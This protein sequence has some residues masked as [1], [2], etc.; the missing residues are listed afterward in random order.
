M[1]DATFYFP[2]DFLW[3]TA[4]SAH[5]VEGGNDNND[6]WDWEQKGEGRVFSDHTSGA[7]CEWWAG[8][9]EEDVQRMADLN[10]NAHRL[11]IE[12]SRIEPREG[13]WDHSAFDRY[14]DILKAML[15]AGIQPMITLHHFTNPMWMVRKGGWLHPE[16]P[17]WFQQF[18]RRVV[19]DLSDLCRVWC[20]INEP[21]VYAA[22]GF[23]DGDWPPGQT[24]ISDY[25]RVVYHMLQAHAAAYETIHDLQ[26][27]AR[28]GLA[29]HMIA[30]YP[31]TGSPLDRMITNLLDRAFNGVTLD[32]LQAGKWRPPVG[33]KDEMPGV[34]NT[35]DWIGLNYYQR[36]DAA[37]NLKALRSL[38]I[39]YAARPGM[40][41]GPEGW[42]EIY[43]DGLF[44]LLKRLHRQFNLPITITE[45]GLPDEH[46]T[47]RPGF[48]LE[49]LYRVW[50]A[51]NFNWPIM[52]YY[53]WSLVD[54]FEWAEGY[55]PRFRFGL[56]GVDFETQ[57]RTLR[58]SG[59]LYAEIA[60]TR[61]FSSHMARRYAPEVVD[62]LF[63]G[64]GPEDLRRGVLE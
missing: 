13:Q 60:E 2:P 14:R 16:S 42:G 21:N 56:Y 23:F 3:G 40:P 36:Y 62:R 10:T 34:R 30:W 46:D 52:G 22:K 17:H 49:S 61:S 53:F 7:A 19:G 27:Q 44:E 39:S 63:P 57:E 32:A 51:I 47:R 54:N 45:N 9:A 28:V 6:W 58:A 31:R 35:L 29:K 38:G 8:R 20:T 33:R 12:W 26:P 43:H 11:S 1:A 59:Q 50:K 18:V 48:I 25:F 4:T 41:K 37:F 24:D 55:D 5:Q 64:Q 15:D